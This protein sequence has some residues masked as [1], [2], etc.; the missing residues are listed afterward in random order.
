MKLHGKL[1]RMD[2]GAGAWVLETGNGELVALY[3]D[4]DAALDGKQVEV[5]GK[6]VDGMGF[7]MVGDRAFEVTSVRSTEPPGRRAR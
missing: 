3:G 4:V 1:R 2:L 7:A 5:R 6:T